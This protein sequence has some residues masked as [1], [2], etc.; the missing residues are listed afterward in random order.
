[1][2]YLH[3]AAIDIPKTI[4][5]TIQTPE[6]IQTV[7]QQYEDTFKEPTTLPS[8]CTVDQKNS[9]MARGKTNTCEAIQICLLS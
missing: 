1:M 4:Q 9:F 7:L 2:V 6:Q 5:Q 8:C 3:M